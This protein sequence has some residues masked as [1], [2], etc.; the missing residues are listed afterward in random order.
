MNHLLESPEIL[1]V[2]EI[3]E[4]QLQARTNSNLPEIILPGGNTS[5]TEAA[6]NLFGLIA[7]RHKLFT[8]GKAVV[9]LQRGMNGASV[10]EPVRPSGAR[11]LFENYA[12][13]WAWRVGRG[14]QPVKQPAVMPEET[15]RAIL[16]CQ[17]ATD[18]LPPITGLVNCPIIIET[19]DGLKICSRGYNLE[20]GL[21]IIKGDRPDDVPLAEAV[22]SL[23]GLLSEFH[24][25]SEGDK[26]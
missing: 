5:I 15:S 12:D 1:D 21:L 16:D 10:L 25:Q 20:T 4:K 18:L 3:E 19:L 6:T 17:A 8:R 13:F 23:L 22:A 11:S 7:P 9:S 2:P 24:F 14:G 26:S